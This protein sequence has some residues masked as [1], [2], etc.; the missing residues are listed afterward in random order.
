M[1]DLID[2]KL[3]KLNQDIKYDQVPYDQRYMKRNVH[4]SLK[5]RPKKHPEF[6]MKSWLLPVMTLLILF[7]AVQ[8]ASTKTEMEEAGLLTPKESAAGFKV[9]SAKKEAAFMNQPASKMVQET[10]VIHQDEQFYQTGKTVSPDQLG[11]VIGT[12]TPS[13]LDESLKEAGE[14]QTETKIF[15]IKGVENQN[16]IAIRSWRNTGI[17]AATISTE[18]YYVFEKS[19]APQI[20]EG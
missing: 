8:L 20:T 13:H 19:E 2:R 9:A 11:E 18:G 4:Q 3:K 14:F 1:S 5:S 12:I 16:K 7:T 17:G 6:K 15:T 10:Y